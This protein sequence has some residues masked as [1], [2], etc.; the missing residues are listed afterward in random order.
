M[1]SFNVT[2]GQAYVLRLLIRLVHFICSVALGW[3]IAV[4]AGELSG[5]SPWKIAAIIIIGWIAI[6]VRDI[7]DAGAIGIED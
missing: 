6:L 3:F 4:A 7:I 1:W 5:G 2:E